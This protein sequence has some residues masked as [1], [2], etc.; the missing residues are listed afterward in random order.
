MGLPLV[1]KRLV[2]VVD[3]EPNIVN[4]VTNVLQ[5]EGYA[6]ARANTAE[7]ALR[8]VHS[9][10]TPDAVLLDLRMP[11]MGGLGFLLALRAQPGGRD[12]PVAVV[13][14]DSLLDDT[15]RR[16]VEALGAQLCFKPLIIGQI[17]TLTAQLLS[18]TVTY[19]NGSRSLRESQ[20]DLPY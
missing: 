13:T 7:D 5:G 8:L 6:T 20:A 4:A 12:I 18:S 15:T 3:D 2:L 14:A 16:A 1:P 10:L 19:R 17:L 11:G 9:G